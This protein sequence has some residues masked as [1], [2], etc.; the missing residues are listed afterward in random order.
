MLIATGASTSWLHPASLK[1]Q[2]ICTVLQGSLPTVRTI[3]DAAPVGVEHGWAR[4]QFFVV[5]KG[6]QPPLA[7]VGK[8]FNVLWDALAGGNQN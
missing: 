7:K 4:C 5:R 1:R 2:G 8:S 6:K 3:C